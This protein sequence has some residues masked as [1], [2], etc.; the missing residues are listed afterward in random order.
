[1]MEEILMQLVKTAQTEQAVASQPLTNG[2]EMLVYPL[3][4]GML[5][6][7]GITGELAQ[8]VRMEQV[9]RRRSEDLRRYGPWQPAVLADGSCYVAR[10]VMHVNVDSGQPVLPLDDLMA[11]EELLT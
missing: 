6:A 11:A 1:M 9:V 10:R 7:L 2:M 5:I 3:D 4:S 8:E